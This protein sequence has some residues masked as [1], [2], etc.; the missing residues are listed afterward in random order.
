L[1]SA[2][3]LALSACAP[4]PDTADLGPP[5]AADARRSAAVAEMRAK[6]ESV[7]TSPYPSVASQRSSAFP[8][9]QS[10]ADVAAQQAE[11]E[12]LAK[13]RSGAVSAA[14]LSRLEARAVE[15][16]RLAQAANASQ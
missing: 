6:A 8:P 3:L 14:E 7:E 15:L 13:R 10:V 5:V 1:A 4:G 9:P 2:G 16:R 12:L 11:L